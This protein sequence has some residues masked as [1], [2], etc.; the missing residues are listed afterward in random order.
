MIPSDYA[1]GLH[2]G[3]RIHTTPSNDGRTMLEMHVHP[4]GAVV[5]MRTWYVEARE[6]DVMPEFEVI[7][8]VH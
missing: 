7:S 8:V 6:G 4:S 2:A 3:T 1:N 5:I